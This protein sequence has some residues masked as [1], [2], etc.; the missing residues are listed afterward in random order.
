MAALVIFSVLDFSPSG[1]NWLQFPF[2]ASY[3]PQS[4]LSLSYYSTAWLLPGIT[5]PAPSLGGFFSQ[6]SQWTLGSRGEWACFSVSGV[7]CVFVRA[8]CFCLFPKWTEQIKFTV[9]SQHI[10]PFY[11]L[12]QRG[13]YYSEK[14]DANLNFCQRPKVSAW[15]LITLFCVCVLRKEVAIFWWNPNQEK[16]GL[17]T[18]KKFYRKGNLY[19]YSGDCEQSTARERTRLHFKP[20][21]KIAPSSQPASPPPKERERKNQVSFLKIFWTGLKNSLEVLFSF[22]CC[23]C[24]IVFVRGI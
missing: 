19:I 22:F 4:P 15:F 7:V 24:W 12:Q 18:A 1:K 17:S 8:S 14:E 16:N 21:P 6:L 9:R 10:H 13:P 23:C 2:G 20:T 3:S 5:K 11:T